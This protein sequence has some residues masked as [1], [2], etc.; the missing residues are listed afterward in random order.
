MD[1]SRVRDELPVW[2]HVL[3][4]RNSRGAERQVID[5]DLVL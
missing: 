5:M 4:R 3:V 2:E 1:P